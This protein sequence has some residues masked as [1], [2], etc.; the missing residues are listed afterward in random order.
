M[1]GNTALK[2][3]TGL[4]NTGSERLLKCKSKTYSISIR[5]Q[6]KPVRPLRGSLFKSERPRKRM[7]VVKDLKSFEEA[8]GDSLY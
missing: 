2:T 6:A 4:S 1:I 7:L 3:G 5:W 8:V